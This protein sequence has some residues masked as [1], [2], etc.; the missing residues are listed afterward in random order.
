MSVGVCIINRNGIA[1]AADSAG[2]YTGNKMFYN[3]MNKVFSLSRKYVY[4]A[5]TYGA[6]TIY[7]VSIDQVLKEFRTYLDS[8]EHISDFFEILPLFEAFINQNSSYYKFDL[9][10]A[11]HCNGLIKDLVVDWGNKIKTVATEVDA[12]NKISEILNQLETVMRGSLKIDNYD[13]S[14]YIKTTYNDYFNMLI[15]MIVP[16]LNNFPTQK[17]CFWDYICNY[18]N[19][20]LTN[21]TNNYMGLF[22]AGYGHCDAFPKFTHIELYRVVGG[23]IKYRLVENYEESNNHAQIVPLAQPDVILTFCKGISNRFINYIPQKVESIINS[24]I[25]ALPDT[26]TIDQ[27]NALKTSLSSSKAEIASAINTTIQNDN[28]KPILDS[29]QLIP[30]PEMGFLA[31]SLVNITSL[32]RTF[33]IDGNQ[34]TVGGPTDVA[35]MSKGDGFVW[36]KRKHYFDKQMNPDY[37]MKIHESQ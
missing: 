14:A 23:K 1:L 22:F 24:K 31:E 2:T 7:N 15:G 4:G 18:F 36:I 13:V 26:F 3:S 28:V 25:D 33:A 34:Q 9:A 30:L 16:E 17:E 20:S 6:T 19:L 29:V 37:I 21:E 12:E 32:K 5:I 8:R 27:K 10:E 35:V 11:N